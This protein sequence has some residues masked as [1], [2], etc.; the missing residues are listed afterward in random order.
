MKR[1]IAA[2]AVGLLTL[3]LVSCSGSPPKSC[4]AS[5]QDAGPTG[6]PPPASQQADE[7]RLG[8]GTYC[9]NAA[10]A[11]GGDSGTGQMALTLVGTTVILDKDGYLPVTLTCNLS[12]Q[13]R[14]A[15][16]VTDTDA[17]PNQNGRLG[18]GG[19]DLVLDAGQTRTFGIPL[20]RYMVGVLTSSQPPCAHPTGLCPPRVD[21]TADSMQTPGAGHIDD[22]T[23]QYVDGFTPV[24]AGVLVVQA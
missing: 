2:L 22:N 24:V 11:G 21:V 23:G 10:V 16:V 15:I 20:P 17:M 9:Q 19:S 8:C 6:T 1:S 3:G 18:R 4:G 13:C 12:Q 5:C 14:G 7:V